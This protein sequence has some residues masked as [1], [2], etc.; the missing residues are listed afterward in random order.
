MQPTHPPPRGSAPPP[1][2]PVARGIGARRVLVLILEPNELGE[3]LVERASASA[4]AASISSS[5]YSAPV[6]GSRPVPRF[7]TRRAR[8]ARRPRR[9]SRHRAPQRAGRS[10]H[11]RWL[12]ASPSEALPSAARGT[13]PAQTFRRARLGHRAGIASAPAVAAT[14]PPRAPIASPRNELSWCSDEFTEA[15]HAS[16]SA[17]HVLADAA[18]GAS[19]RPECYTGSAFPRRFD[20]SPDDRSPRDAGGTPNTLSRGRST[21]PRVEPRYREWRP[22]PA[23]CRDR[24]PAPALL[25][26]CR[27]RTMC[28][29]NRVVVV[30]S[31]AV[32]VASEFDRWPVSERAPFDRGFRGETGFD[33][34]RRIL[35]SAMFFCS[36]EA[37]PR[38]KRSKNFF[39]AL[40]T[41][42]RPQ[43][44]PFCIRTPYVAHA[45]YNNV[46][47]HTLKEGCIKPIDDER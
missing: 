22:P 15:K 27:A 6:A 37:R 13:G 25:P 42:V 45:S 29:P 36:T 9:P 10:V 32:T 17:R 23:L 7:R 16:S 3:R 5:A 12:R 44:R 28:A 20:P 19:Y 1:S 21:R 38:S 33:R 35:I 18:A 24:V 8:R 43:R 30:S 31:R 47:F 46:A 2:A 11:V 14:S 39:S 40:K 4:A 26:S 41:R 34:G